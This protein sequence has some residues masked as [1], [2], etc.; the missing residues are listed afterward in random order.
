MVVLAIAG[1]IAF[2]AG[3]SGFLARLLRAVWSG[4]GGVLDRLAAR[5]RGMILAMALVGFSW[6]A[7]ISLV[8]E[9]PDPAVHDEFG[10]LL[11][12][13]TFA[14]GRLTNPAPP[15]WQGALET[16]HVAFE[17]T[18]FSKYPAAAGVF[19]AAG[20]VAFGDPLV[21][22]WLWAALLWGTITW[23]LLIAVPGRFGALAAILGA[24]LWGGG[25]YWTQSYWGGA[26]AASG[27]AL[28]LGVTVRVVFADRSR[29]A[30]LRHGA[31]LGLGLLLLAGSRPYEGFVAS[32]PAA[33]VVI[34]WLFRATVVASSRLRV[35]VAAGAV[36]T[37]CVIA[38]GLLNHAVT[39]DATRMPYTQ[40]DAIYAV[41]P[42]WLM[43]GEREPPVYR[44]D[45]LRAFWTEFGAERFRD[46]QSVSG[47]LGGVRYTA[48][49]LWRFYLGFFLVIPFMVGLFA[50]PSDERARTTLRIARWVIGCVLVA[51]MLVASR[52]AHYFAPAAG[53]V[54]VVVGHG[55]RI[56][57]DYSWRGRPSGRALV[58]ALTLGAAALYALMIVVYARTVPLRYDDFG[59][60]RARLV[61]SLVEKGGR[62]LVIVRYEGDRDLH[63]E[64]VFNGAAPMEAP[65]VFARSMGAAHDEEVAQALGVDHVWTLQ[66]VDSE[67]APLIQLR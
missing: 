8:I 11:L 57:A 29:P 2:P 24:L 27:G 3:P 12:A 52:K 38:M 39:G 66:V 23:L 47:Y 54:L 7:A 33:V 46:S 22:V 43:S 55:F 26:V 1:S 35:S 59:H 16:F 41:A 51:M 36:L 34:R 49:V 64:W 9:R 25:S 19:L 4:V 10:Y 50:R 17:P 67:P 42:Q 31:A 14:H 45:D 15:M 21:G 28:V 6:N 40:H 20:Q 48:R 65:V 63:E 58:V 5:P 37:L 13:D 44:H 32:L 18:Y 62:H 56:M 61:Q 30:G 53:A 60:T